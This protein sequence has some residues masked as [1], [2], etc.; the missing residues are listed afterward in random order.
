[1]FEEFRGPFVNF[2]EGIFVG[3]GSQENNELC[4]P[5]GLMVGLPAFHHLAYWY[6]DVG[7]WYRIE[8]G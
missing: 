4:P 7:N 5:C 8:N 1:M 3:Y 6:T 2:L